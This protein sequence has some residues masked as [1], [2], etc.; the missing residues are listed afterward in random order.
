MIKDFEFFHGAALAKIIQSGKK[1][2]SIE[3]YPS[4]SNASYVVDGNI[5]IYIKYSTKRMSPWSFSFAEL[6][7]DEI[8]EMKNA[9]SEVYTIL[10][11]NHDGFVCL[12]FTELKVLL[13]AEH[14]ETEWISVSRSPR[15]KYFVKGADGKLK[16]KIGNNE[17]PNKIFETPK[18]TTG[19]FTWF[20]SK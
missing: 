9:L 2:K 1:L 13:D 6:H 12:S 14:R 5:G 11:C 4:K 17:F 20:N 19:V 7:Q 15:E 8:L 18:N 10:V 3:E 16:Y